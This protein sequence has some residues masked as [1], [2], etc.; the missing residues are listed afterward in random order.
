MWTDHA[1]CVLLS[2]PFTAEEIDSQKGYLVQD[3]LANYLGPYSYFKNV[4]YPGLFK[5]FLKWT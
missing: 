4:N 1:R 2:F 3:H 5:L